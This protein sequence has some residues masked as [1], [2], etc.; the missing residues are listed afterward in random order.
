MATSSFRDPGG[1]VLQTDSQ[2]FRVIHDVE[3]SALREFL[4][5]KLG[6]SIVR[7]GELIGSREVCAAD[8]V[9][10]LDQVAERVEEWPGTTVLEHDR[11][12]FASYPYEWPRAMLQEAARITLDLCEELLEGGYGLKDATPNNVLFRGADA[13]F[14]D[15][16]SIEKRDPR[17]PM[18]RPLAQFL[19]TFVYPLILDDA[20]RTPSHETLF[21]RREGLSPDELYHR[22]NWSQRLRP[23]ALR[24]ASIPKWLGGR[25]STASTGTAYRARKMDPAAARHVLRST[26]AGLR[27]AIFSVPPMAASKSTWSDYSSHCHYEAESRAVKRRFV[28]ELVQKMGPGR[29]LDLGANDGE[30]SFLAAQAGHEVVACDIDAT[31]AGRLWQTAKRENLSVL[32]LVA[33]IASPSPAMGWGN[34]ESRSLL[35]RAEGQ[36]DCVLML[37]LLHHLTVTER[38]P[39]DEVLTL[40]SRLTARNLIVEWVSPRDP[41]YRALLRGR[42]GLHQGDTVEEFER[43]CQ[44]RFRIARK[45]R[46]LDGRRWLY[47]LEKQ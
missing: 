42:E 21:G 35:Q 4:G 47:S 33:N 17:D 36:F 23:A 40:A 11:I 18:W 45:T 44:R 28:N 5:S 27:R 24:W 20:T 31:A 26:F 22:L 16:L 12:W 46:V 15:A 6:Q 3:A 30:Y 1:F 25:Q 29:V 38:V 19:Q 8:R 34:Q 43:C 41:F 39:L 9:R 14:I 2:I 37:A 13:V 10:V 7:K 32:P